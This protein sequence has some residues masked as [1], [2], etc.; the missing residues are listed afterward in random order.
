MVL[1]IWLDVLAIVLFKKAFVFI[2]ELGLVHRAI[3]YQTFEEDY[4]L[5]LV[6][7][8]QQMWEG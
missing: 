8:V 3:N 2:G 7:V 4:P 1:L 6:L 5:D